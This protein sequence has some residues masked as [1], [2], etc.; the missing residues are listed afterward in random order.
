MAYR[1][2]KV[3]RFSRRRAEGMECRLDVLH[4]RLA[5]AE[6][7]KPCGWDQPHSS[8]NRRGPGSSIRGG[9]GGFNAAVGCQ[10]QAPGA[11]S[12]EMEGN[13]GSCTAND[14][15]YPRNDAQTDRCVTPP[16]AR[17]LLRSVRQRSR[18]PARCAYVSAPRASTHIGGRMENFLTRRSFKV[19]VMKAA[20]FRPERRKNGWL[21]A[22]KSGRARTVVSGMRGGERL[23]P[24]CHPF[25]VSALHM[26]LKGSNSYSLPR[27]SITVG[28][29]SC[30]SS[31]RCHRFLL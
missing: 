19:A 21:L 2:A 3:G 1:K 31:A 10:G 25:Q 27:R 22:L 17:E 13:S 29:D 28:R 11:L 30:R 7:S 4:R 23:T 18:A 9:V 20:A 8:T 12:R 5:E 6:E 26:A 24:T 14:S 16:A 15:S